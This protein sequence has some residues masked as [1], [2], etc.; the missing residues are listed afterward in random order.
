[1][2]LVKICIIH[3]LQDPLL[4]MIIYQFKRA[5]CFII[6]AGGNHSDL[7]IEV[8]QKCRTRRDFNRSSLVQSPQLS[9]KASSIC[10]YQALTI[11]SDGDSPIARAACFTDQ[12]ILL[13]PASASF[14]VNGQTAMGAGSGL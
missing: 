13:G 1:M 9:H 6:L 12:S 8:N 14:E 11:F 3:V 2:S 10:G 4:F 5:H 7:I